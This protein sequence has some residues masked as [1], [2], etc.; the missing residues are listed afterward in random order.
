NPKEL[1]KLG[2]FTPLARRYDERQNSSWIIPNQKIVAV[3]PDLPGLQKFIERQKQTDER[4]TQG[5]GTRSTSQEVITRPPALENSL[6]NFFRSLFDLLAAWLRWLFGGSGD[7]EPRSKRLVVDDDGN[8]RWFFEDNPKR[9]IEFR[10]VRA[11]ECP[12]DEAEFGKPSVNVLL[13]WEQRA[14]QGDLATFAE[15]RGQ[16]D[17]HFISNPQPPSN[18]PKPPIEADSVLV[19]VHDSDFKVFDASDQ[20]HY[21][22]TAGK[23]SSEPIVAVMDTGLKYKWD[24]T[25]VKLTYEDGTPFQFSIAKAPGGGCLPGAN[26]GYCS[27]GDYLRRPTPPFTQLA[28]LASLTTAEIQASPYDDHLVDEQVVGEE[29]NRERVGRHGTFITAILNRHGCQVLPVKSFNCAARGTLF[30]VLSGLN[31]LIAQKRAGMS[32]KVLNASFSGTLDASGLDFLYKKMK[33]LTDL[34]V[35]VVASAGNDGISLDGTSIYPA[36]F[37]LSGGRYSIEKVVTVNSN[38]DGSVQ[39]NTGAA[40][41]ITAYSPRVGGFPSAVAVKDSAGNVIQGTSFAAPY[42]ACA[43]AKLNTTGLS[44]TQVV[45]QIVT[46]TI[47]EVTFAT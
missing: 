18:G 2:I 42:V 8:F 4:P 41:S 31:Y 43:L 30:D 44:K 7:K 20:Q 19:K 47:G 17:N 24:K 40:V 6:N 34:G 23:L 16:A 10:I 13:E 36:Q 27:I 11:S 1:A 15:L 32:I 39:G 14:G 33:V 22:Q 26:F 37:G 5:Q 29:T 35:W 9:K 38:Y 21:S 3:D 12:N 45:S 25:S 46:Q 28:T